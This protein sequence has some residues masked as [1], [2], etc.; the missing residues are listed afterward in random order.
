MT[1]FVALR[2]G[3][4][5]ANATGNKDVRHKRIVFPSHLLNGPVHFCDA[6]R[7]SSRQ[8]DVNSVNRPCVDR[9]ANA[10]NHKARSLTDGI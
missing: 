5:L 3:H 4:I 8:H 7:P 1:P 9:G 2:A 6:V 10:G